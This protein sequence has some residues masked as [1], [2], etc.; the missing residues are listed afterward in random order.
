[1]ALGARSYRPFRLSCCCWR[2]ARLLPR[3][4]I[5]G[6]RVGSRRSPWRILVV[7]I[8]CD[9]QAVA[10]RRSVGGMQHCL[11]STGGS[12]THVRASSVQECSPVVAQTQAL[13]T[14][15][16]TLR[17]VKA[18]RRERCPTAPIGGPGSA[19]AQVP[20]RW[21]PPRQIAM[22]I[23]LMRPGVHRARAMHTCAQLRRLFRSQLCTTSQSPDPVL[24][25]YHSR[26]RSCGPPWV[27][28]TTDASTRDSLLNFQACRLR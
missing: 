8:R 7:T 14:L 25:C 23:V 28:G 6:T 2:N 26:R 22:L 5:G 24:P 10:N 13:P 19:T 21:R 12:T 3:H 4:S 1:M 20:S 11:Q 9:P 17:Y 15:C 27:A 16:F 18:A